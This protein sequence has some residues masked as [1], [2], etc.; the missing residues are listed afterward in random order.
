[1]RETG[2][3]RICGWIINGR[4]LLLTEMEK[5]VRGPYWG[6]QLGILLYNIKSEIHTRH[7]KGHINGLLNIL[8]F[9]GE[10]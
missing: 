6:A 4:E 2:G 8:Q 3:T 10:L 9:T 5:T 1:M 7:R